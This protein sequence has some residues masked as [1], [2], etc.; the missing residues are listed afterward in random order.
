MRKLEGTVVFLLILLSSGA[1]QAFLAK[2]M[3][4]GDTGGQPMTQVVFGLLYVAIILLLVRHRRAAVRL[5]MR[6]KWSALMCL[7]VLASVLWSVEPGESLRRALALA[8]TVIAS[9][10]ISMRYEPKEQIKVLA[11][12]LGLGAVASVLVALVL[13]SVAFTAH[14][15]FQGIYNMKNSLGRMMAYGVL[16]FGLLALGERRRRPRAVCFLLCLLCGA[17]LVLS[18]SAT[19]VVVTVLML[20]L[21]PLRK[22]LY[23]SGKRLM[24]AV[25]L[26]F[27][28]ACGA[29]FWAVEY[30]DEIF[31]ALGRTS[32]LTGRIPLWQLVI[33][34]IAVKPLQGYGFT[35]FW[36]SWAGQRV[37][38]TVAWT[39]DVPN[40]HN[41]FLEVWLGLGIVGLGL[42]LISMTR[43]FILA[44]RVAGSRREIE[45]SWPLLLVIFTVLYNLTESTLLSV[46]SLIWIAYSTVS[47]W[48]TRTVYETEPEAETQPQAE[49]AFSA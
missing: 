35:A 14:F 43:N 36:Q 27:P 22:L 28:L 5:L 33:K 48:L 17:L 13:P 44:L 34:E 49:P 2:P 12:V 37:S 23:L 39:T 29:I 1:G 16:C 15:G 4:S 26:L 38:D 25:A 21:L 3:E 31:E 7:W 11:W 46:N 18:G 6:E 45:Y 19:A 47:F 30:S 24:G 42:L 20:G 9:L 10:Y 32:S 41:G 40:S 8:G